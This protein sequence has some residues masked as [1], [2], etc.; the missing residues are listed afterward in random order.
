[1]RGAALGYI[2]D[3]AMAYDG[4]ECLIWPFIINNGYGRVSIDGEMRYAHV[5]ICERENGPS[6]T[7]F[8]QAAHSCGNGKNGCVTKRHLTWKTRPENEADKLVHGT[9]NRGERHPLSKL[10]ET[11]ARQILALK[12]T[13]SQSRLAAEYGV[14]R[15]TVGAIHRGERWGWLS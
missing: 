9:H 8:H 2:N 11:D 13:V 10:S 3:V 14:T 15:E 6:P 12:G 1:M 5:I 4:D 7:P